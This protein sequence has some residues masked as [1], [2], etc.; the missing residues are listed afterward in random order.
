MGIETLG[1]VSATNISQ[2]YS[3]SRTGRAVRKHLVMRGQFLAAPELAARCTIVIEAQAQ[4]I[5]WTG[6][7]FPVVNPRG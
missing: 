1:V 3:G 7:V 5:N 2:L 6:S 4:Q